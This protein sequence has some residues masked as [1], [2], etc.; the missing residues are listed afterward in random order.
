MIIGN[1]QHRKLLK[2][3][4]QISSKRNDINHFGFTR[5]SA[6]AED[7]KKDLKKRA[8]EFRKIQEEWDL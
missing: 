8:G 4:D 6:K 5:D 1:E 2:L 3:M 7:L